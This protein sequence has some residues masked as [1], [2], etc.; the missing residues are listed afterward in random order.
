MLAGC[1]PRSRGGSEQPKPLQKA[2]ESGRA[3]GRAGSQRARP[4]PG[5]VLFIS[6]LFFFKIKLFRA[7]VV[8]LP[9]FCGAPGEGS[10]HITL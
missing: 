2:L 3:I 1:S 7:T 6:L 5:V 10:V 8:C 9:P 4:V